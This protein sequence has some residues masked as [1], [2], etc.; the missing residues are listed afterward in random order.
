VF[1][2]H[3]SP[4]DPG[5]FGFDFCL[6]RKYTIK[7]INTSPLVHKIVLSIIYFLII[8]YRLK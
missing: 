7:I 6:V 2:L 3:V 4:E 8:Y 1:V 5:N